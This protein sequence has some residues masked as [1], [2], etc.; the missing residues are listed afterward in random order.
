MRPGRVNSYRWVL[1]ATDALACSIHL[2][3]LAQDIPQGG[4]R[5]K[6]TRKLR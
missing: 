6:P 3:G 5:I 2:I 4:L 1:H